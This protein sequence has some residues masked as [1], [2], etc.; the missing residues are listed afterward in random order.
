MK[1]EEV[2]EGI[3]SEWKV[4]IDREEKE[5]TSNQ[6][7]GSLCFHRWIESLDRFRIQRSIQRFETF[8]DDESK[9]C[10]CD[11]FFSSFPYMEP[12]KKRVLQDLLRFRFL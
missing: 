5:D 4:E 11:L 6:G 10:V 8:L 2:E 9:N 1:A 7:H 3:E 12:G